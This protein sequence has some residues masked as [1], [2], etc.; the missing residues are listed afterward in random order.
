MGW[1]DY[2]NELDIAMGDEK[3][4]D[5]LLR[6]SV[7]RSKEMG[8][9]YVNNGHSNSAR[10]G[11]GGYQ[12]GYYGNNPHPRPH[13]S[14]N[15]GGAYGYQQRGYGYGGGMRGPRQFNMRQPQMN[16]FGNRMGMQYGRQPYAYGGGMIRPQM[17]QYGMQQPSMQ[18]N[19]RFVMPSAIE[20]MRPPPIKVKGA[21]KLATSK[22][23]DRPVHN[24][25]VNKARN[26]SKK[27]QN[28]T[29]SVA[30]EPVQS[31][32]NSAVSS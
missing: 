13:H 4:L 1:S 18:R 5:Q 31:V 9:H 16:Q 19:P 10:Q 7:Y 2:F 25:N 20:F 6:Y 23:M 17:N 30:L 11:R 3:N 28:V 15:N 8:Y 26:G 24:H 14:Y 21:R 29:A 12:N 32:Y 22:S 27:F